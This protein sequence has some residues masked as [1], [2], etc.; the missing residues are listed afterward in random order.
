M[1]LTL[2]HNLLYLIRDFGSILFLMM[3]AGVVGISAQNKKANP[4]LK[5]PETAV[6]HLYDQVT[7]PA[8]KTPDWDYVRTMFIKNATVVMRAGRNKTNTLSLDGWI[9]DFVN[10]IHDAEVKKTGF[11]E[12]IVK[13]KTMEFGDIAHVL[14]L[15]TSYIPGKSKRP[16]EGV[17]SF[18]LIK[19][20][21]EWKIVSILNE[22]PTKD[23]PKPEALK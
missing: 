2:E 17:D 8:G 6:R 19:K 5:D 15:Y 10:F 12:K 9:L 11:E 14:V 18:H 7:F 16:R 23:R 4:Q 22:I 1:N 21:G 20:G 13:L 3:I